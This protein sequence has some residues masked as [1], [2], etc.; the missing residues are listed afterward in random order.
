MNAANQANA[1]A[2]ATQETELEL[3]AAFA[4]ALPARHVIDVGAGHGLVLDRLRQAAPEARFDAF[5]PLPAHAE[6]LEARYS[7]VD[8][9][10]VHRIAIDRADGEAQ[11]HLARGNDG[12]RQAYF[13]SLHRFD[14]TESTAWD[15]TIAVPARTLGGLVETEILPARVDIL[16]VDTEGHDGAVIEGLG[17]LDCAVIM[18]EYWTDLPTVIGRCPWRLEDMAASL[19]ERGFADYVFIKRHDEYETVQINIPDCEPGAWGNVLFV[20]GRAAGWLMPLAY[21]AAVDAQ[22]RLIAQADGYHAICRE[23]QVVIDEL[24]AALEAR[25]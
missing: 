6:A 22:A 13:H 3:L 1:A 17:A 11:L 7:A 2:A 19:R 9:V 20:A 12:E 24:A 16:K 25:R 15:E 4:A 23:R 5:E 8:N 18:V 14:D 10:Q 21:R